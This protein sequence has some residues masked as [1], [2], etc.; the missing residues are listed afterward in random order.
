MGANPEFQPPHTGCPNVSFRGKVVGNSK[1]KTKNSK[2][3]R[4]GW[5]NPASS[6]F[7]IGHGDGD[8]HGDGC[9]VGGRHSEF[10]LPNF[11]FGSVEH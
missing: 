10:R 4:G 2:L 6:I 8:G 1:L 7:A 3:T 9:W 5:S 11:Q